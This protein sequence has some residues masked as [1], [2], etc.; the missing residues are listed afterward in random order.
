VVIHPGHSSRK[1]SS[2]F[3]L[4]AGDT[5]VDSNTF[6]ANS[7]VLNSQTR[8]ASISES[9]A[10]EIDED[11]LIQAV[12]DQHGEHR[13]PISSGNGDGKESLSQRYHRSK[14]WTWT[15][16]DGEN[17]PG[18]KFGI[19]GTSSYRG[20]GG[21]WPNSW[22]RVL[23]QQP[24]IVVRPEYVCHMCGEKGHHIRNCPKGND[25]KKHKKIKPAT[26]MPRSWLRRVSQEEASKLDE[27]Y[28]LPDGSFVVLKDD[29]DALSSSSFFSKSVDQR[30]RQRLGS[31]GNIVSDHLKCSVCEKLFNKA[32]TTPCCGESF[33]FQ[34][35][36]GK[37]GYPTQCPG[38]QSTIVSANDIKSIV[39]FKML[40]M[41]FLRAG[42]S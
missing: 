2:T 29:P 9:P 34:C 18:G 23:S 40:L 13:G 32:V 26:G 42:V 38:C 8:E 36:V 22:D 27:V 14:N 25:P 15:K 6:E 17:I 11:S 4:Q 24:T 1:C 41:K 35:V 19:R 7:G 39:L 31:S 30:I 28:S 3:P 12:I 33:C 37:S 21:P 10:C 20:R 16:G 5:S